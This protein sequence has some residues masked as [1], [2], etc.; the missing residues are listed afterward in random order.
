[1]RRVV[2]TGDTRPCQAVIEAAK[3]ADVLVHDSTFL[4]DE[5][6]RARETGHST[7]AEAAAVAKQAAVRML[8][9]TH[10]SFRHL[11]R[12]VLHEARTVY[13]ACVLPSDFDRLVIPFAEKGSPYL[14]KH[15]GSDEASAGIAPSAPSGPKI[16]AMRR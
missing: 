12:D 6:E 13:E 14:L 3:G 1:G 10:L 9:L 4:T 8:A 5:Q 16:E 7:A 2:L 11:G 15:G